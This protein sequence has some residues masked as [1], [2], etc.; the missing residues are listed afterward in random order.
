MHYERIY[1]TDAMHH[2][3]LVIMSQV[4]LSVNKIATTENLI[5]I[6]TKLVLER[7]WYCISE[8]L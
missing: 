6:L 8:T 3:I 4:V 5:N 1:H 2:F 7:V